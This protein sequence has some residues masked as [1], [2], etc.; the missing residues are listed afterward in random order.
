[1]NMMQFFFYF[2]IRNGLGQFEFGDRQFVHAFDGYAKLCSW[3]FQSPNSTWFST[4]FV[5]THF[6]KDSRA[7]GTVAPYLLFQSVKPPFSAIEKLQALYHGIDNTNINVYRFGKPG[8]TKPDF[9]T[10]SDFWQ[11]YKFNHSS[12][13][14]TKRINADVPGGTYLGSLL[15]LPSTAHPLPEHNTHNYI[16][17]VTLMNPLPIFK[18]AIRL[19]RITSAERRELIA[20][21]KVKKAPYMHSF[22]LSKTY[23]VIFASPLYVNM[24]KMIKTAEPVNSLDWVEKDPTKVF[25]INIKTGKVVTLQTK[26]IFPMHHINAYERKGKIICDAVTYPNVNFMKSLQLH[27]LN[28]KTSRNEITIDAQIKRFVIDLPKNR[29]RIRDFPSKPI[30]DF[31]RT[32]DMPAINEEYRQRKYC[33]V[34]GIVLKSDGL[35]LSNVTLVKKGICNSNQDLAWDQANHYPT[36]PWFIATPG[37][38]GEDDGIIMS[39]VLDGER[40]RSYLGIWDA[41]TM[42]LIN[43][44]YLPTHIPFTLHGR[45]FP[46]VL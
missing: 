1:M 15:P 2:Q 24:G 23:A 16:N 10:V 45:F 28:N 35:N 11:C 4:R 40:K 26:A 5:G 27:I 43:K 31:V 8:S 19:V 22:A 18:S 30:Y 3:K 17:L 32:L 6:F 37:G 14:T 7:E 44:S 34:Y 38:Q 36:E 42:T 41:K 20:E 12:L 39:L 25:V 29:V 21:V 46:N 33:Y 13:R 9:V